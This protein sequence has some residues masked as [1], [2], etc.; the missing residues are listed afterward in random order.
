[1]NLGKIFSICLAVCTRNRFG[2][3]SI[4]ACGIDVA[5]SFI[6]SD[7]LHP[8]QRYAY[9]F[10]IITNGMVYLQSLSS[11]SP[12]FEAVALLVAVTGRSYFAAT[13]TDRL[14]VSQKYELSHKII[15]F[16]INFPQF[17][18]TLHY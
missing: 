15:L 9:S 18:E 1:M 2:H 13:L 7:E 12:T 6:F 10:G 16:D 8:R 14:C 5:Q 4:Y 3:L 11:I 17:S